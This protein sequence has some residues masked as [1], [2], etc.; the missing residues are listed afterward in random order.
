MGMVGHRT[1][2][3]VKYFMEKPIVVA[4]YNVDYEKDPKGTNYWRNRIMKVAKKF[5]DSGKLKHFAI[6]NTQQL[7][8]EMAEFGVDAPDNSKV[9][10]TARDDKNQKFKMDDDFTMETFEKFLNNLV[11]KN[12]VAYLKSEEVPV[13]NDDP[14]KVVVAKQFDEIVND[15]TKDVLI[16]FYAPWCGHC[17]TL[18][19]KFEELAKKL[20]GEP[21]VVIAKM[22][23]TA[24]DVPSPYEVSGFPTLYFAPKNSKHSPKLY[25]GGR[26]VDDMLKHIASEASSPLKLYNSHGRLRK[27]DL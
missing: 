22:D 1:S 14:V 13:T 10:I 18:A 4:F 16:E 7:R 21:D 9:Y 8:H 23:A 24:N 25:N 17:K 27:S 15:P 26:E 12:L 20:E 6:S 5:I 2:S 11:D 3:S 19:P